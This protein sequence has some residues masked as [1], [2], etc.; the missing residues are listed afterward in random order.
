[1]DRNTPSPSEM[2]MWS[3]T[4]YQILKTEPIAGGP[5]PETPMVSWVW[6]SLYVY[7]Q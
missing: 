7:R 3:N 5:I 4:D 6:Y 2:R 1:M